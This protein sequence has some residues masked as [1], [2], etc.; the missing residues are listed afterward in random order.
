[1]PRAFL[2][3]RRRAPVLG[4]RD[5]GALVDCLRG[6]AYVPAGLSFTGLSLA[7]GGTG[8]WPLFSGTLAE[9]RSGWDEAGESNSQ[10]PGPV[11]PTPE[12][13]DKPLTED[14]SPQWRGDF[15][16][17]VCTKA[18]P[19]QRLLTRHAKCHSPVKRHRCPCCTK[20][21]NDTFDLKRHMRTHTGI[22]PYRC[23]L[24]AKA[25]TQRCSL[26]S[27]LRKIHRQPQAYGYR[28]RRA[29]LYVCEACGFT[30][31]AGPDYHGHLRRA[32]PTGPAMPHKRAGPPPGSL[33]FLLYPSGFYA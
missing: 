23:H 17:G 24:C 31:T 12:A 33:R 16:C 26:E 4:S 32:H 6:D 27:H 14:S 20:G 15:R 9:D 13:S 25:F 5:W 21:F 10:R 7:G 29:K 2:V 1:M 3:R 22:R 19:L 18:F 8:Q 30:C 11:V 28:E